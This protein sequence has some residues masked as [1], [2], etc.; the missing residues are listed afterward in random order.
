MSVRVLTVTL[1][2]AG[3]VGLTACGSSGEPSM[4]SAPAPAAVPVTTV[5]D[6]PAAATTEKSTASVTLKDIAFSPAKVRVKEGGSVTWT[7]KD[8]DVPHNVTFEDRHSPTKH[9]GTYKL[10]F[11]KKGTFSYECTIHPGM[12][13][14]VVVD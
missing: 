2:I 14:K 11:A 12:V 4:A 7:W 1:A 9:S 13:A 6:A 5:P 3:A 8:G 10:T